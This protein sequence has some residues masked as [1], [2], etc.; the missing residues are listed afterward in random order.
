MLHNVRQTYRVNVQPVKQCMEGI[1]KM[2]ILPHLFMIGVL[3][4]SR[5]QQS[6]P[7][8]SCRTMFVFLLRV[9]RCYSQACH[10][11]VVICIV[12][13]NDRW[14]YTCKEMRNVNHSC[15]LQVQIWIYEDIFRIL[16]ADTVYKRNIFII[17]Y[18]CGYTYLVMVFR[19]WYRVVVA[20]QLRLLLIYA[21]L[22]GGLY[23]QFLS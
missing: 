1:F 17:A 16:C 20:L 19:R 13:H 4:I 7:S 3:F 15:Q 2:M 5:I 21:S 11:S 8:I 9:V 22:Q 18:S 12:T 6:A 14:Y 23:E 10:C